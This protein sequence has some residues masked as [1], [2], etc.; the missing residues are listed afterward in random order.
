VRVSLR[1]VGQVLSDAGEPVSFAAPFDAAIREDLRWYLEDYL[2][3]PFAVYAERG[4]EIRLRLREWGETLF[5]SIFGQG[6]PGRDAYLQAREGTPELAL[7]SR[8]PGFLALPWEL[9]KD[10][11]REAPLALA[12]PAFDRTLNVAGPSTP[13]PPGDV[14]LRPATL[15]GM[16]ETLRAAADAGEPLSHPAF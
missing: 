2:I 4:Q 16:S 1:R 11:V 6:K 12:M 5:D 9:V 10:S 14:L 8:S 3:A 13:V 7:I 15:Q